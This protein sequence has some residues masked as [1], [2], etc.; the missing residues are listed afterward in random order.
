M[1]SSKHLLLTPQNIEYYA[2]FLHP[3]VN[4]QERVI[5]FG[6]RSDNEPLLVVPI[7]QIDQHA[8]VVLTLGQD[9]AHVNAPGVDSDYRFGISDGTTD[10]LFEVPDRHNYPTFGPCYPISGTQDGATVPAGTLA[11]ATLKFTFAPY[12]KFAFCE[13]AQEGG[14]L[15]TGTFDL[16]IDITKT[17]FLTTTGN[18]QDETYN[19]HYF[20][21]EIV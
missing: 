6:P 14:F 20:R 12:S 1:E 13:T 18:E 11:S 16:Q 19:F 3:G 4:I 5:Q 10:N 21:V 15:N 2:T 7:G 17:L 9:K 8:T